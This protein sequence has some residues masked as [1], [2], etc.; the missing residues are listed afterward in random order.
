MIWSIFETRNARFFEDVEFAGV[1]NIRDFVFEEENVNTP[2]VAI[3]NDQTSITEIIQEENP[4]EDN[5][6]ETSIPNQEI[7][8]KKTNST[9]S[10]TYAIKEIH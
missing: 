9:A 8:I 5:D 1:D 7:V 3:D 10:R 2:T 4:D 6:E